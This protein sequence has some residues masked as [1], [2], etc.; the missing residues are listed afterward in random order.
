M[1]IPLVHKIT[2]FYKDI[3][4][5]SSTLSKRDKLGIF[6]KIE[7]LCLDILNLVIEAALLQK[8]EKIPPVKK[9][10]L[11]IEILKHL[12]RASHELNIIDSTKYINL[13]EK[14]VEISKMTTGWLKYL[15]QIP[16]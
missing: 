2:E 6:A 16:H 9:I 7:S 8:Q 13:E 10:K 4:K 11:K 3:Y 5:L 12:I 14:L 1:E 15:T